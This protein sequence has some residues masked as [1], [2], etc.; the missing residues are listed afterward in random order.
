MK[1]TARTQEVFPE[2]TES[3]GAFVDTIKHYDHKT[4]GKEFVLT[5]EMNI[6]ELDWI[7]IGKTKHT[8]YLTLD[9][10]ETNLRQE[11]LFYTGCRLS[12][13][14]A[15]ASDAASAVW[16]EFSDRKVRRVD[17]K[18]MTYWANNS[19]TCTD[20]ES[21][22]R[23]GNGQ[24]G[25]WAEF[26]I[27]CLKL[28]GIADAKKIL[29]TTTYENEPNTQV[30]TRGEK[31]GLMLVK[32]WNFSSG[33]VPAMFS[34]FT[35]LSGEVS[36]NQNGAPGQGNKNPPG[37][38][39]NH[40]I[41]KYGGQYYDPSYGGLIYSSKEEWENASLDGFSKVFRFSIGGASGEGRMYKKNTSGVE[42]VFTE[43]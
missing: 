35:H 26:F 10:P 15:N 36:D 19:A 43:L 40:F 3:T 21:L 2:D 33:S 16:N 32:D 4:S 13:G 31:R 38:F 41:V 18:Q 22:I 37:A 6:D 29:L 42:T 30:Y 7:N 1:D 8:V 5:W 24:C 17:G 11:T 39:Y 28:H 9:E 34:P 20:T 14:K 27:D 23:D 25:S 12:D